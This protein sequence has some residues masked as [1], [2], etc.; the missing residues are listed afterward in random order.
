MTPT[1]T[2]LTRTGSLDQRL[3]LLKSEKSLSERECLDLIA[4]ADALRQFDERKDDGSIFEGV[5]QLLVH[6]GDY[7]VTVA[8]EIA[9][10]LGIPASYVE[11]AI[12]LHYPSADTQLQDIEEHGAVPTF[13]TIVNT[14]LKKLERQLQDDLPQNK[15][16]QDVVHDKY[17]PRWASATFVKVSTHQTKKSFLG[18]QWNKSLRTEIKLAYCSFRVYWENKTGKDKF[19]LTVDLYD[20]LFLRICGST[21]KELNQHFQPQIEYYEV[22]YHYV[23]E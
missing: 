7:P 13:L 4:H 23:V 20:P 6:G 12:D 10:S 17:N 14:Y 1:E 19:N 15:I 9:Q 8:Y 16:K 22:K 11:Q 5:E 3:A 21:L 2:S 18:W